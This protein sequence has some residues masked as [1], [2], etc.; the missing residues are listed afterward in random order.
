MN[1]ICVIALLLLMPQLAAARVYMC[2]DQDTGATNFTDKACQTVSMREEVRVDP[3]NLNS[4]A[5]HAG[6][7]KKKTWRSQAESR[8][9]GAD[10]SVERRTLYESKASAGTN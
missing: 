4:G 9:S 2:V 5:R 7:P 6:R 3:V 8:K 1:R 10:F